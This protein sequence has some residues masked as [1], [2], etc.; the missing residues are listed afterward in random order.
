MHSE[1]LAQNTEMPSDRVT[2]LLERGAV[3]SGWSFTIFCNSL[4]LYIQY[5]EEKSKKKKNFMQNDLNEGKK[6]I[7]T[8][9]V[10][11]TRS[12]NQLVPHQEN[13]ITV[14]STT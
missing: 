11:Q 6:I 10:S 14:S 7:W 1:I 5:V 8:A 4:G 9:Q 12:A 3:T 13:S 2:R